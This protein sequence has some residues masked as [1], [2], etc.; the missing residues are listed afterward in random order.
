MVYIGAINCSF[1]CW[2]CKDS[3]PMKEAMRT[4]PEAEFYRQTIENF[5]AN[6]GRFILLN[7]WS[8]EEAQSF[9]KPS[10][11]SLKIART[12]YLEPLQ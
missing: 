2:E 4:L 9:I 1:A 3:C 5:K 6:A 10:A 8:Y 12:K 11:V 7:G